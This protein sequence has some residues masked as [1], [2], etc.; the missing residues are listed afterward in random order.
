MLAQAGARPIFQDRILFMTAQR[1]QTSPEVLPGLIA[2]LK[3]KKSELSSALGM[4]VSMDRPIAIDALIKIG[5]DPTKGGDHLTG[6]RRTPIQ[7][8]ADRKDTKLLKQL[9]A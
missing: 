3:P 6:D 2:L 9:L 5:A 4:A 7:I 1:S 8:A